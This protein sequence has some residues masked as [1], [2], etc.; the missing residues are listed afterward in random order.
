MGFLLIEARRQVKIR[1]G[2]ETERIAS[3][4]DWAVFLWSFG[5][6]LAG[7]AAFVIALA[8][9]PPPNEKS[10]TTMARFNGKLQPSVDNLRNY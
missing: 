10:R 2:A 9:K 6:A 7:A 1:Q 5:C 3:G 8:A 4:Y